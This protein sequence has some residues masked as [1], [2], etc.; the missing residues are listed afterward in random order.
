M[1]SNWDESVQVDHRS[2]TVGD[3][4]QRA[5]GHHAPITLTDQNHIVKTLHLNVWNDIFDVGR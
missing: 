2:D 4:R 1:G 5:G 3:A